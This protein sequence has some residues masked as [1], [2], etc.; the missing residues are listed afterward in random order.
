[1][2]LSESSFLREV[3]KPDHGQGSISM[4]KW[5][6]CWS[7]V[8]PLRLRDLTWRVGIRPVQMAGS[9]LVVVSLSFQLML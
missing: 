2:G 7:L 9:L 1:M 3:E 8:V 6:M 4:C 5:D